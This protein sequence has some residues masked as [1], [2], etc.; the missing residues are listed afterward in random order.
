MKAAVFHEPNKPLSIEE[1]ET[2]KIEPNEIL[3][4]IAACGVCNTD[5]HYIDHGVPTFKKPP[6]ILGHEPSGIVEE[7]GADVK[8]FK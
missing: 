7:V 8:D 6:I 2:P 1:V 5:L 3:V 4:K